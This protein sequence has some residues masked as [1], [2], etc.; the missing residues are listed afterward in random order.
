VQTRGHFPR[1][2]GH[3]SII[4][5]RYPYYAKKGKGTIQVIHVNVVMIYYCMSEDTSQP[6]GM[7]CQT[8]VYSKS[9]KW[10]PCTSSA[11]RPYCAAASPSSYC[12]KLWKKCQ[13]IVISEDTSISAYALASPSPVTFGRYGATMS[14]FRNFSQ[15]TSR[16]HGWENTS[17]AP[18]RRLP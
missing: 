12:S 7:P 2:C 15:S 3:A 6:K 11:T 14:R 13:L 18:F 4:I 10:M 16:N 9:G 1:L 17:P 8:A 5:K